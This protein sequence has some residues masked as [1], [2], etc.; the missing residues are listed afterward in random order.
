V[1]GSSV[2]MSLPTAAVRPSVTGMSVTAD[3][4]AVA[5]GA[6]ESGA[7]PLQPATTTVSIA[8]ATRRIEPILARLG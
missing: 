3:E 6:G 8:M 5:G 7:A 4:G 2:R 1:N